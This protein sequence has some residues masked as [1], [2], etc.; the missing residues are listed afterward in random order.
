MGVG[1]GNGVDELARGVL[2]FCRRL[3]W[4]ALV[5]VVLLLVGMIVARLKH[6]L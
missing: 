2:W 3:W 1:E 5:L 4:V 6:A